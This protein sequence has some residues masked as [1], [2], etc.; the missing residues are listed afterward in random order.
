MLQSVHSARRLT[1]PSIRSSLG[2]GGNPFAPRRKPQTLG[3]VDNLYG[4]PN[5][6]GGRPPQTKAPGGADSGVLVETRELNFLAPVQCRL[7]ISIRTERRPPSGRTQLRPPTSAFSAMRSRR[8]IRRSLD[9]HCCGHRASDRS[10]GEPPTRTTASSA[11][12]Y[13][14]LAFGSA[15]QIDGRQRHADSAG[16]S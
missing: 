2:D 4:Q 6:D 11:R 13:R 3:F 16:L 1:A 5:T 7:L 8:T 14:S 9:T 15:R 10:S 12:A